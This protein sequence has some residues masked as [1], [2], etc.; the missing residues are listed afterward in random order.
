[1]IRSEMDK[2]HVDQKSEIEK[3]LKK[4]DAHLRLADRLRIEYR[5]RRTMARERRRQWKSWGESQISDATIAAH[6]RG[7]N[8]LPI[9]PRPTLSFIIDGMDTN[10][11]TLPT[12]GR[13]DKLT[14]GRT[15]IN[16]KVC[17]YTV[18]EIRTLLGNRLTLT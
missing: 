1:M 15:T 6:R 3:V 2:F 10:K 18:V 13:R 8:A 17:T 9:P 7:K 12:D 4:R 5:D 16:T 11:T 14:D